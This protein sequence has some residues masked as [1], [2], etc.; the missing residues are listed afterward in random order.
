MA[1]SYL[2][3]QI[4]HARKNSQLH[5][6]N[7]ELYLEAAVVKEQHRNLQEERSVTY[8]TRTHDTLVGLSRWEEVVVGKG[9][10]WLVDSSIIPAGLHRGSQAS[11]NPRLIWGDKWQAQEMSVSAKAG[12]CSCCI[13][14]Q[15]LIL[16]VQ[17]GQH[18]WESVTG[19]SH[20]RVGHLIVLHFT[21]PV[22]EGNV[23]W[24]TAYLE[25]PP[26]KTTA[27]MMYSQ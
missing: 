4:W 6:Q 21:W 10:P 5:S 24:F 7:N 22:Y 8:R 14:W 20:R 15:C 12:C 2:S 3:R 25:I 27:N 9:L 19:L 16:P 13:V 11:W 1:R 26:T 18:C 17:R 23:T